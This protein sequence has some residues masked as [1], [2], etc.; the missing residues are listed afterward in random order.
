[1]KISKIQNIIIVLVIIVCC[2]VLWTGLLYCIVPWS[3]TNFS[4]HDKFMEII[5]D[6]DCFAN[7]SF[8]REMPEDATNIKYYW[9][10]EMKEKCA[11]YSVC[12]PKED[13]EEIKRE[14][15]EHYRE[16]Q[17]KHS[18]TTTE[19]TQGLGAIK[20]SMLYMEELLFIDNVLNNQQAAEQYSFLL[21]NK[22]NIHK[23]ICY[24]GIIVNDETCEIIEFTYEK[25]EADR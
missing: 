17:R 22:V 10:R 14:R 2:Y 20:Q 21:V 24:S 3:K 4:S 16:W 18:T 25:I 15:G 7:V 23:G 6:N 9:Y 13:Y 1:M 11:A 19:V 12:V 8:L 5:S